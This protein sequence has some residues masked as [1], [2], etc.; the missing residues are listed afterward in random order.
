MSRPERSRCPRCRQPCAFAAD[1]GPPRHRNGSAH[2][3]IVLQSA[4]MSRSYDQ[5]FFDW[6]NFPAARSARQVI[7]MLIA[8]VGPKSIL[9]VGCGQG[10][11]LAVWRELGI[12]DVM[13]VDGAYV[14]QE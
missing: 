11:W 13:G 6:V 1:L 10:A 3:S 14:A 7:P 12:A 9:D 4:V 8:H 2:K 5:R